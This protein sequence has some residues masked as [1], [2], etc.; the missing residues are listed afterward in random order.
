MVCFPVSRT[1]V[2]LNDDITGGNLSILQQHS[3]HCIKKTRAD[4]I[5]CMAASK[6]TD[7]DP[8]LHSPLDALSSL[9]QPRLHCTMQSSI[10]LVLRSESE[11]SKS[12]KKTLP[13]EFTYVQCRIR[14]FN[15]GLQSTDNFNGRSAESSVA[16]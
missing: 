14:G 12:S 10:I 1:N 11:I 2:N 4:L 8:H 9:S 13:G 7:L 3:F 16:N 6:F 15:I 5:I